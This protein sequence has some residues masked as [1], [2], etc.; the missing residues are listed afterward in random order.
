MRHLYD[1]EA[2]QGKFW[3]HASAPTQMPY[4][5]AVAVPM[6]PHV[7]MDIQECKHGGGGTACNTLCIPMP[8]KH[9][10]QSFDLRPY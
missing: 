2:T 9:S 7:P 5:D 10:S 6:Q 4:W 3:G 1:P 8:A